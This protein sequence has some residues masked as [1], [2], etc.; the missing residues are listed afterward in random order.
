MK[1]IY[2]LILSIC[3]SFVFSQVPQYINYQGIARD[4]AGNPIKGQPV[5]LDF[6]IYNQLTL[7]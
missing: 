1:K 7:F 6:V 4:I 3:A 2:T 5:T